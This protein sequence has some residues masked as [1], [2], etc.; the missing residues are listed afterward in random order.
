MVLVRALERP[1]R[2]TVSICNLTP[3]TLLKFPS[4][5]QK[6]HEIILY[7]IYI[8]ICMYNVCECVYKKYTHTDVFHLRKKSSD[9]STFLPTYCCTRVLVLFSMVFE[10][11]KKKRDV[12]TYTLSHVFI[13]KQCRSRSATYASRFRFLA[14][15]C[16][17]YSI[18]SISVSYC[19]K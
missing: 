4:L 19:Y 7:I 2:H 16:I 10:I 1:A 11:I 14:R 13:F 9:N 6:E 5:C 17:L 18:E 3:T 8:F 12:Y 15:T